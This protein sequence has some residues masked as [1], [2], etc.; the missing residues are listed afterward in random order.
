MQCL[1][2]AF[3]APDHLWSAVRAAADAEGVKPSEIIR[4]AAADYGP[5]KRAAMAKGAS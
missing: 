1:T 2:R 5:V 3:R 4:R